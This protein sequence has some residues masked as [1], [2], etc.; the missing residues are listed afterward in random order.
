MGLPACEWV[1]SV[2]DNGIGI[3]KPQ[4]ERIFEPF[5]KLMGSEFPGTGMGLTIA[6]AVVEIYCG[7]MWAESVLGAGS[8]F[9]FTVPS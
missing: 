8:T 7:K 1:F 6:Q 2:R 4:T 9:L 5:T 3:A